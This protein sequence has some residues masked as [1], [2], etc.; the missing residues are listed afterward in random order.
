[1]LFGGFWGTKNLPKSMAP[2][3]VLVLDMVFC[4]LL[5]GV[6]FL[7]CFFVTV[8]SLG[9][10]FFFWGGP[11]SKCKFLMCLNKCGLM[12]TTKPTSSRYVHCKAA[13]VFSNS[14]KAMPSTFAHS[15]RNI[16]TMNKRLPRDKQQ[17]S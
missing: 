6:R 13:Q 17:N 8:G 4:V 1:M 10:V 16:E 11:L 3:G 5:A 12:I 7:L 2:L 14:L 9:C 15:L